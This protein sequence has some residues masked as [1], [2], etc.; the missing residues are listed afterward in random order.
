MS[1]ASLREFLHSIVMGSEVGT[2][3]VSSIIFPS[4]LS[5]YTCCVSVVFLRLYDHHNGMMSSFF[6]AKGAIGSNCD[7]K[8]GALPHR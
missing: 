2:S 7:L 6:A 4:C 8:F 3:I 5:A 1:Y